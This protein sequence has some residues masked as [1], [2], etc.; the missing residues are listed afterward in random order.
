MDEVLRSDSRLG[1]C[2]AIVQCAVSVEASSSTGASSGTA[3]AVVVVSLSQPLAVIIAPR[4][5]AKWA[6][7]V[8]EVSS[9][10]VLEKGCPEKRPGVL[11][12]ECRRPLIVGRLL[13][14]TFQ[15]HKDFAVSYVILCEKLRINLRI[16]PYRGVWV[17]RL[18]RSNG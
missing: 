6:S 1:A 11:S 12:T 9:P 2:V 14:V 4:L 17:A 3:A 15:E 8:E 7:P 13:R 5:V 18:D 16:D 10:T